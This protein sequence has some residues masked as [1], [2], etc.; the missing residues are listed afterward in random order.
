ML[1]NKLKVNEEKMAEL[2]MTMK[3]KCEGDGD[4]FFAHSSAL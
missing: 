2:S 4:K 3:E 1:M